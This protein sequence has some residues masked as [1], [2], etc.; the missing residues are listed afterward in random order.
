[1]VNLAKEY[2]NWE[3]QEQVYLL[4]ESTH[5]NTHYTSRPQTST[6][7]LLCDDGVS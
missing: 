7:N 1:M 4:K 3:L 5:K 2:L 6:Q